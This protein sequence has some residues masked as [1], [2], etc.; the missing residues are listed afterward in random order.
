[1]KEQYNPF[2]AASEKLNFKQYAERPRREPQPGDTGTIEPLKRNPFFGIP[3]D[4]V[5]ALHESTIRDP[6][7][8]TGAEFISEDLLGLPAIAK[9]LDRLSY[10]DRLTENTGQTTRVLPET[11]TAVMAAL[12]F[13]QEAAGMTRTGRNIGRV[14]SGKHSPLSAASEEFARVRSPNERAARVSEKGWVGPVATGDEFGVEPPRSSRAVKGTNLVHTHPPHPSGKLNPLSAADRDTGPVHVLHADPRGALTGYYDSLMSGQPPRLDR[15]MSQQDY[16]RQLMAD[17]SFS[18]NTA[19][20]MYSLTGQLDP[21]MIQ[22]GLQALKR[23]ASSPEI[24]YHA[25]AEFNRPRPGLFTHPE[26][27][28]AEQYK[29]KTGAPSLHA[30]EARP[31][32]TGGEEDVYRVARELGIYD[33]DIP[34]GQY[35]EQGENAVFPQS[36][37]VVDEL[38]NRGFD[39]LR[40]NDGMSSKPSLVALDPSVLS[41]MGEGASDYL[42]A[43][44]PKGGNVN[45]N[46][47]DY[48]MPSRAAGSRERLSK[49]EEEL[50]TLFLQLEQADS[51]V[52]RLKDKIRSGEDLTPEE[53]KQYVEN[54]ALKRATEGLIEDHASSIGE[55]HRELPLAD[56]E[57]KNLRRY[58]ER[59]FGSTDD[60]V[61][62]MIDRREDANTEFIKKSYEQLRKAEKKRQAKEDE[63]AIRLSTGEQLTEKEAAEYGKF[64]ND[65][66][67]TALNLVR[68]QR[69]ARAAEED[70]G[71]M[72]DFATPIRKSALREALKQAD[73]SSL[74]A[75]RDLGGAP[76]NPTSKNVLANT[77]ENLIDAQNRMD[78]VTSLSEWT[79]NSLGIPPTSKS[80][81]FKPELDN[82][83]GMELLSLPSYVRRLVEAGEITEDELARL[84][85]A[86]AIER[87]LNEGMRKELELAKNRRSLVDATPEI[88]KYEDNSRWVSLR[89]QDNNMDTARAVFQNESANLRHCI[90]QDCYIENYL[91]RLKNDTHDY[92]SLRDPSGAPKITIETRRPDLRS[93]HRYLDLDPDEKA[94]A[95]EHY[96]F[97]GFPEEVAEKTLVERNP[98]V[99]ERQNGSLIIINPE[100]KDTVAEYTSSLYP[101]VLQIKSHGNTAP[102]PHYQEKLT[103][104]LTLLNPRTIVEEQSHHRMLPVNDAFTADEIREA[105]NAGIEVPNYV[106]TTRRDEIRRELGAVT[107]VEYR[108]A[109]D[110][111]FT[112]DPELE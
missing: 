16:V 98:Y 64:I 24:V 73:T 44:R 80:P 11:L 35:L 1:M 95:L 86:M 40:I 106:S 34:V 27:E 76:P 45:M 18:S 61:I 74:E 68:A 82:Q 96:I 83:F 23:G 43:L 91:N 48:A 2:A 47:W 94:K 41:P 17:P 14:I 26:R 8:K 87:K 63:W 60:S 92:Y 53:A 62:K 57:D 110:P 84:T 72:Q 56:W 38:R 69:A 52:Q 33:P 21:S 25:G 10:G 19:E 103:D 6:K 32:R 99:F 7:T 65:A 15:P 42:Q 31:R 3:S 30:F 85:P 49:L 107:P 88:K 75:K 55:I 105:R 81:V 108:S 29:E 66:D 39:S 51:N 54:R 37:Q 90:G 5:R 22:G 101:L 104:F 4:I 78:P 93:R 77:F 20:N 109:P 12:P 59:E 13:A 100:D 28:V 58:V 9:T 111:G 36:A 70:Y 50:D 67:S 112:V 102:A 46:M 79:L 71:I 89:P 97:S